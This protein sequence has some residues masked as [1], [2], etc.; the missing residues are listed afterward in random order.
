[1]KKYFEQL[2]QENLKITVRTCDGKEYQGNV[3]EIR[4]DCVIVG[5]SKQMVIIPF[6]SI[7]SVYFIYGEKE[8]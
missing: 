1:M 6:H 8:K 5:H 4:G 3:Q 2:K 7:A